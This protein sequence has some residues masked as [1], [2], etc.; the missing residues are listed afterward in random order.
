MSVLTQ[1]TSCPSSSSGSPQSH[2]MASMGTAPFAHSHDEEKGVARRPPTHR[3]ETARAAT[4]TCYQTGERG[5]SVIVHISKSK[6]TSP[7]HYIT[8]NSLYNNL[9]FHVERCCEFPYEDCEVAELEALG[10]V[11]L[12]AH[13]AAQGLAGGAPLLPG[14]PRLQDRHTLGPCLREGRGAQP[15]AWGRRR[16]S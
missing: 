14:H 9:T 4:R 8:I 13:R 10:Q 12:P 5:C 16:M 6:E 7:I 15:E 2:S 3:Y 11:A 1:R